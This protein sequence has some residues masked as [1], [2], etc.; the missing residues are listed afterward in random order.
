MKQVIFR[1]S[2]LALTIAFIF[3]SMAGCIQNTQHLSSTAS[4]THYRDIPG[5]TDYQIAAIDA[6]RAEGTPLIYASA[7]STELYETH[8]GSLAG[9]TVLLCDWLSGFFDIQF[10]PVIQGLGAMLENLESG[11]ISFA[12]LSATPERRETYYMAD[13]AQRSIIM[14]RVE[15]SPSLITIRQGR[16][17]RYI[18]TEGSVMTDLA[19]AALEPGSYES[20]T[21]PDEDSAYEALKNGQGDAFIATNTLE[22]A[23]DRHGD[24]YAED[25]LPLIFQPAAMSAANSELKPIIDLVVKALESGAY[26]HLTELYRQGYQD[27]RAHKFLMMLSEAETEYLRDN[28][29]IPYATQYMSYPMSFFNTNSGKWEGAVFDIMDEISL[30]SGL[31]FEMVHD[32]TAELYE[33]TRLLEDGTAYFMPNLIYSPERGQRFIWTEYIYQTDRFA[34]LSKQS[35]PHVQLNDIPFE[36]VG[37]ARGSAFEDMFWHWFPD[38]LYATEYPTTDDAFLALDRGEVD[39]VLSSQLRLTALTNYYELSDYKPNYLFNASFDATFGFNREQT[40]LCSIIDKALPMIDTDRI[41]QQWSYRT[42][43][44]EAMRLRA[45]RPWLIGATALSLTMLA[46]IL[47]MFRRK[48]A[49]T[50]KLRMAVDEAHEAN[51]LKDVSINELQRTAMQLEAVIDNYPGMIYYVDQNETV[52]LSNGLQFE[53]LL[54]KGSQFTGK[55]VRDVRFDDAALNHMHTNLIKYIRDAFP[56]KALDYTQA[57]GTNVYRIRTTPVNFN[58]GV[59]TNVLVCLDNVTEMASLTA[60]MESILNSINLI[61]YVTVPHTGEIL[62]MNDY[63][64]KHFGFGD[65]VIGKACYKLMRGMDELC[66]FCPCHKLD[67]NPNM[68][69]EWETRR[70]L[71]NRIYQN[72]NKYISWPDGQTVHLQQSIDVTEMIAAKEQAEQG[73]R[74]KS[75]FLAKMSHEIRTPMNAIIGLTELALRERNLDAVL[76]HAV[77]VKHAS[78]ALLSIID[79]ILDFSKIETGNLEIV[80]ADYSVSSLINDVVSIIRMRDI[81]SQIRFAVNLDS[82]IPTTLF[83]DE[84]RIRQALLNILNNAFKYTEKGFVSLT[85]HGEYISDDTIN[86]VF[87]VKDSGRGIKSEDI[88]H[89]FDDFTQFDIEKNK[90]IKGVGLGLAITHSIVVAMNGNISVDSVYGEG[91]TFTIRLPQRYQVRDR[92]AALRNPGEIN[93]LI[94]EQ[95]ELYADSLSYTFKNLSVECALVSDN[96]ELYEKLDSLAYNYLFI[97]HDLYAKNKDIILK[98]GDRIRVVALT[99]F[100]EDVINNNLNVLSM[101]VY[102]V[103]AADILNGASVFSYDY[104]SPVVKFTAPAARILIVDDINTNLKVA[105]GLMLP[106]SMQIDLCNSGMDAINAIQSK[107]YDLVFMDHKMPEMDGIEA[108]ERIRQMGADDPYYENVPIVALT[109]NAVSGIKDMLLKNGF[110]DF[111]SKPIDSVKLADILEKW[112]P[113]SKQERVE[114]QAVEIDAKK[115][116]GFVISGVDV[117]KGI[118]RS[119]GTMEIY[120]DALASFY[121]D[122]FERIAEIEKCLDAGNLELYTVHTHG[123]KSALALIGADVLSRDAYDLEM[124][125]HR[126]DLSFINMHNNDFLQRLKTLLD[127][128]DSLRS[129][130]VTDAKIDMDALKATLTEL[131]TALDAF[132]AGKMNRIPS[133]LLN[134]TKGTDLSA[135]AMELSDNILM[136]EYDNA[137]ALIE[138]FIGP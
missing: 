126:K 15:G 72:L 11:E 89:L 93:V 42:Y 36:R 17:P 45:Q 57:V 113:K 66:D 112:I 87:E 98:F 67:I 108:T 7:R 27:Y 34:L 130:D 128:V 8:D 25:F 38:A 99:E 104:Y 75:D 58:D 49:M 16:L 3:I 125:G 86:I 21:V 51:T 6:L 100:G 14:L 116:T 85:A 82:N 29:V 122:G 127:N 91:S 37:F 105:Q 132:D 40:V 33:L 22:A 5:I 120:L 61:I 84:T 79:D 76:E 102:C 50:S 39:L 80:S 59:A 111:L 31:E 23:F 118:S 35:Y 26:E 129:E 12:T 90:G 18:F 64:R 119:G 88:V 136:G 137:S 63:M 74:A 133:L 138:R 94:Y 135:F 121:Q 56:G 2:S 54:A 73:S 41:V 131:S 1:W 48:R 117:Q 60:I 24:I 13:I 19:R 20:V 46:L 71:T 70:P 95:Q 69:I 10:K 107:D 47:V 32:H 101:P 53:G 52:V 97:S 134:M 114:T 55:K 103:Q 4:I 28:P 110:D 92:V 123:I 43:G 96:S 83:G 9:Y 124:A 106:Y 30:L 78:V 62:F 115:D 68:T 44:I 65:D 81:D 77:D 109:A